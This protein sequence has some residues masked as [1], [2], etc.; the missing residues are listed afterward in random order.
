MYDGTTAAPLYQDTANQRVGIAEGAPVTTLEVG[1]L[2][3]M[4]GTGVANAPTLAIDNSSSA[5][6]NHAI[7]AFH[8]N[9]AA[10]ETALIAVG[11]VG[12]TK[13]TGYLG[14]KYSSAGSDDNIISL[15]HWGANHLLNVKGNGNVGIGTEDPKNPLHIRDTGD[16]DDVYSGIRFTPADSETSETN[17]NSYHKITG[18]RKSGLLLAGGQTGNHSRTYSTLNNSGYKVYTNDGTNT[19]VVLSTDLKFHI[20]VG[21][22]GDTNFYTD[23][24][25]DGHLGATTKSFLI[26]HPTKEGMMLRHGSLEGPEHGVYIRGHAKGNTIDLPEY[27]SGLVDEESITVQITPN[28]SSQAL[29]VKSVNS[30]RVSI[31]REDGSSIDCFYFIQAERKD[32]GK[33]E[34]EYCDSSST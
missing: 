30:E 20:A 29:Y 5:S 15:S 11:R 28:L 8:P 10:G 6:Y 4:T 13:N 12:S 21:D 32:V 31:G 27:W 2:T 19:G 14:Y 26:P 24:I 16:G 18:F 34:V 25:I 17:T 3:T 23:V 22:D 33:M 1:G 7:E 9:L